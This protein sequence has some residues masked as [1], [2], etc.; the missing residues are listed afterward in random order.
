MLNYHIP[1]LVFLGV[2]YFRVLKISL[3]E[4]RIGKRTVVAA[5]L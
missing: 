1:L 3:F 2:V 5:F 4:E